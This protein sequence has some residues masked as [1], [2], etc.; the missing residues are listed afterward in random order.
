V[1]RPRRA[2]K[3]PYY[4]RLVLPSIVDIK[5]VTSMIVSNTHNYGPQ[6]ECR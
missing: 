6:H 4:A 1:Q 3:R 2:S 5:E